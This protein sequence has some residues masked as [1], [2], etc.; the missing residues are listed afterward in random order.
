M[1]NDSETFS[2]VTVVAAQGNQ[3]PDDI[4]KVLNK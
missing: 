3:I 2:S 1:E 4:Q